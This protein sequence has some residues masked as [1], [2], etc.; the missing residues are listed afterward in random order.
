MDT[1]TYPDARVSALLAERFDV[2]RIDVKNVQAGQR[3]IVRIAR[4]L[5][6][7]TMAILSGAHEIRRAVGYVP[8][9]EFLAELETALG[10]I[11]LLH[12][13]FDRALATFRHAA[14]AYR[15]AEALYWAGVAAF[16]RAR[17][18]DVLRPV[19]DELDAKHP[20]SPWARR[21]DVWSVM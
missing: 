11:D 12:Q 19:W 3:E 14:D 21:A 8:P 16:K 9:A 5:W 18:F 15:S 1:V 7:P 10:Q 4:P 17:T 13:D 20:G 2:I 6:T